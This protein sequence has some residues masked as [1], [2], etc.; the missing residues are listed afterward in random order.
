M[1][2]ERFSLVA[3]LHTKYCVI[4]KG[5]NVKKSIIIFGAGIRGKRAVSELKDRFDILFVVDNDEE[6]WGS[7]LEGYQVRPPMD[8]LQYECDIVITPIRICEEIIY[9]LYQIGVKTD[10]ICLW[11]TVRIS[12][13]G[14]EDGI[15]PLDA[16]KIEGTRKQLIEYDL[17]NNV[18][19]DTGHIKV[20]IVYSYYSVYTKQL[21]ENLAKRYDD[22]EFSLLTSV[23]ENKD[24]IDNKWLKHIYFFETDLDVKTILE[25]LPVYDAMQVLWIERRWAYFY[26]LLRKKTR[27]LNLNVGGSEFYR[28]NKFERDFKKDFIA[29]ADIVTAETKETVWNFG[30]YYAEEAGNKMGL[31]PFGIE[32]LE[33]IQMIRK[34][35]KNELK[36]K[37]SIPLN[38]VV[39][40]CAHNAVREN[41]HLELIDALNV[42]PNKIRQQIVCVF[43]MTYPSN[44]SEY[45]R[46]VESRLI[47]SGLEYI[48][49]TKFMDFRE[50]AEYALL[51]DIMIR[52]QTTDQLSSMMLEAMYAGSLV[53]AG[54]WLPYQSLRRM[55]IYFLDVDTITDVTAVLEEVVTNMDVYKGKCQ[56]NAELVWKHSSW[57]E[58][59]PKWR[60]LWE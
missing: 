11:N 27:R 57:D 29:C 13:T 39:V 31:L 10:K 47:D 16:G 19:Q 50:M 55:G 35:D 42:L 17:L 23:K 2:S 41:R 38:K 18:E 25:Q 28:A 46:E 6:K 37:Y 60:A 33:Y 24:N 12:D 52:V 48:V 8:V 59:A 20:L 30:E 5:I 54:S 15:Y 22:I 36:K 53:I 49:L 26:K 32:V 14:F 1:C 9:Q 56:G 44:V 7:M 51:S 40:T 3:A 4:M 43:P 45:I 21:V 34:Q 58:L